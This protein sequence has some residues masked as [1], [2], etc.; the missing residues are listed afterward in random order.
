[1]PRI[2]SSSS[3]LKIWQTNP[4][5]Q[6]PVALSIRELTCAFLLRTCTGDWTENDDG[7]GSHLSPQILVLTPLLSLYSIHS[8]INT[9][10]ARRL[11]HKYDDFF[12]VFDSNNF[13]FL[14]YLALRMCDTKDFCLR[15]WNNCLTSKALLKLTISLN[16]K[17]SIAFESLSFSH[18]FQWMHLSLWLCAHQ[19]QAIVIAISIYNF[20]GS[21]TT[22]IVYVG[23]VCITTFNNISLSACE[24]SEFF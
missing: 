12:L 11:L 23:I 10:E 13:P 16:P 5:F 21:K 9:I 2:N 19:N 22:L 18:F 17:P 24:R 8:L 14:K 6:S 3:L 1:M 7:D 4:I 15:T 20:F